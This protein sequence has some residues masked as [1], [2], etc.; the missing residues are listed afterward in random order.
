MT[1]RT[2]WPHSGISSVVPAAMSVASAM[3]SLVPS[4][5][6]P[7][8]SPSPSPL[9]ETLVLPSVTPVVEPV[10]PLP[11]PQAD[12]H[13]A[14]KKI[15]SESARRLIAIDIVELSAGHVRVRVGPVEP[16]DALEGVRV[17]IDLECLGATERDRPDEPI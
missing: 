9:L 14:A 3:S 15:G 7:V 1:A 10:S 13:A 16:T 8:V 4:V 6:S 5:V 11:V 17:G 2:D 12:R